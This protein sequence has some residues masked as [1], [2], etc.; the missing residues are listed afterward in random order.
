MEKTIK[1]QEVLEDDV[2]KWITYAK[3]WRQK[4]KEMVPEANIP[5]L[6]K[7]AVESQKSECL[8]RRG[9]WLLP[10]Y[11]GFERGTRFRM[12]TEM[13]LMR[14]ADVTDPN[15]I[16]QLWTGRKCLAAL[17]QWNHEHAHRC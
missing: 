4:K 15:Q 1:A 2:D 3:F 10:R 14:K 9:Q 13:E 8:F 12:S 11:K 7:D 17:C 6:W 5:Q 16:S